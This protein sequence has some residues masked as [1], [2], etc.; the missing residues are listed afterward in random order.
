[1][2]RFIIHLRYVED[3]T[4]TT[5]VAYLSNVTVPKFR[6]PTFADVVGNMG[7]SL[8][9]FS[10]A[11]V[12][13]A[14]DEASPS[15]LHDEEDGGKSE[16]EET[17]IHIKLCGYEGFEVRYFGARQQRYRNADPRVE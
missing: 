1:M 13:D 17:I 9:L 12:Q 15:L 14:E 4:N 3:G 7:G 5:S 2:Q 8:E 16:L 6:V 11:E 10:E